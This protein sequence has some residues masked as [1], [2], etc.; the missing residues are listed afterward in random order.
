VTA[1]RIH[2]GDVRAAGYCVLGARDWFRRH[3]LDW[4]GFV[5]NGIPETD[6]LATGDAL[7][8]RVIERKRDSHG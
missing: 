6:L 3:G 2:L 4:R 5:R 7:A 1:P 8:R